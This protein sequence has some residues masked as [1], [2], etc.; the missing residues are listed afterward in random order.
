[1]YM[2]SIRV[3]NTSEIYICIGEVRTYVN[4][5]TRSKLYY[6]VI[7]RNII[8]LFRRQLT[9]YNLSV[10]PLRVYIIL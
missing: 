9:I 8:F 7:V 1:M 3:V 6:I 5:K 4:Y 2:C 10:R